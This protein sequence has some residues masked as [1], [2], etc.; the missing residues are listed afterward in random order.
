[1][2]VPYLARSFYVISYDSPGNGKAERTQD[3]AAFGYDRVVDQGIRLLDHL[4]VPKADVL[5]VSLGCTYGVWMAARYP[6]RVTRLVL[7]GNVIT[8]RAAALIAE[9]L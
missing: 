9:L 8:L 2:Q 7:I 6:E 1:M 3:P 4:E 5:G